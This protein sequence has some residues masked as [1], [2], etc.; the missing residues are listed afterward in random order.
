MTKT[1]EVTDEQYEFFDN[2]AK[3]MVTQSNQG[4][5]FPLFCVYQKEEVP[6][7]AGCGQ[8]P[9]WHK[10]GET[11]YEDDLK[12]CAEVNDYIEEHP[13]DKD[14]KPADILTEKLEYEEVCYDIKDVP[15]VGQVYFTEN[16][17][18]RHIDANSY[19]YNK[20]FVYV[21]G[22]WRNIEI[23]KLMQFFSLFGHKSEQWSNAYAIERKPKGVE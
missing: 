12:D 4:T 9:G 16:A 19:H 11:Y 23:Q 2:I 17:A 20:P 7:P 21:V 14:M 6:A 22:A 3:E 1:I 10:D 8:F 13:E 15:V 5:E 18:Q